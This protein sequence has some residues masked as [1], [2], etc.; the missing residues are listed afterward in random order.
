MSDQRGVE[1]PFDGRRDEADGMVL[2]EERLT[3]G[4]ERYEV[5]RVEVRKRRVNALGRRCRLEVVH[6]GERRGRGRQR[7]CGRA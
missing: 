3:P 7:G 1:R 4:V 5:G 2:H 6:C